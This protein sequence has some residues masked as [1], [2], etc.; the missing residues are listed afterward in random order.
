MPADTKL[1][2]YLDPGRLI[3]DA[4]WTFDGRQFAGWVPHQVI[5]YLWPQGPWYWLGR[6]CRTSRLGGP[7]ALARHAVPR[8]R[9]RRA[10]ARSTPRAGARCRPRRGA[11]LPA[12]AVRPAV[13]LTHVGDAAAVGRAGLD[14]RA[15]GPRRDPRRAGATPPSPHSSSPRS[16]AVNATALLMVAPAPVLWLLVA[17]CGGIDH[18]A[19]SGRHRAAHRW[20]VAR[21]VAVVDRLPWSIQGRRGADV[22]AYSESLESVSY[23]STSPEVWRNLG[24]WLTYVRDA[25]AA[26]DL[27]RPRLHGLRTADRHRVRAPAHRSRRARSR[28]AGRTVASPS[29]SSSS[30]SCSAS[31]STRSTT[32][33]R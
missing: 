11:R 18:V 8:R 1:Y 4:P 20:S 32:R 16:G 17:A 3:S 24:Y 26:D 7:A 27:G 23:T 13:R 28:R 31:A 6:H 25:Y 14:R 15:D 5:A 21:R 2:L 19:P 33:R 9:H 10:V 30:A 29:P 22:L 12:H